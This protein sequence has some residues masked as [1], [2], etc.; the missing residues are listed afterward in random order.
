MN[1]IYDISKLAELVSG[2]NGAL[3]GNGATP[4]DGER[5]IQTETGQLAGR[6]GDAVGPKTQSAANK[7]IDRDIK[8]QLTVLPRY[9]IFER[10]EQSESS[11]YSDFTWLTASPYSLTGINSED[12]Q[13]SASGAA[14]YEMLRAGQKSVPRG[15]AYVHLGARGKQAVVRLN[16]IRVTTAAFNFVRNKIRESTGELRASFYAVAKHYV[17]SKPIPGWIARKID[18]AEAKGKTSHRDSGMTGGSEAFVEFAARSAGLA[19]NPR[20]I[21]KVEGAIERSRFI[22]ASKL[23]KL[24][25][26]YAYNFQTGAV[27]RPSL[28]ELN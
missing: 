10:E 6:I 19:S 25:A 24:V 2:L 20:L 4:G 12:D 13:S 14:A 22:L 23:K 7:R 5:M 27:Y 11:A 16:R 8:Q 3:I 15:N 21:S 28:E 9:S 26:G 18:Q 1:A 17:P